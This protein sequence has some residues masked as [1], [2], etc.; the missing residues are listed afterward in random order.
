MD[1]RGGGYLTLGQ[2][3]DDV[4]DYVMYY[5]FV[6]PH[7]YNLGLPQKQPIRTVEL[8]GHYRLIKVRWQKLRR[9]FSS[10]IS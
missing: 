7:R 1:A 8:V 2:A 10:K 3:I 4:R 9:I 6:R 5:N